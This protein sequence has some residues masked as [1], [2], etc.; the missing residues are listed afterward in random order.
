M[1]TNGSLVRIEVV[2][3]GGNQFER[4][5]AKEKVMDIYR[6]AVDIMNNSEIKKFNE[7]WE[8]KHPEEGHAFTSDEYERAYIDL[9]VKV[10]AT[11]NDVDISVS[12]KNNVYLS[13]RGKNHD[14]P[15]MISEK[16][17]KDGIHK[18]WLYCY[19]SK[20]P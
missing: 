6:A 11:Q 8:R 14:F 20:E 3:N 1:V 18:G 7:A 12:K 2:V 17:D 10:A 4:K 5:R 19:I 16:T 15:L 9:F 13:A